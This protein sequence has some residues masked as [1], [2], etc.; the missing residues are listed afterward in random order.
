MERLFRNIKHKLSLLAFL[1]CFSVGYSQVSGPFKYQAVVR[2]AQGLIIV[3]EP[4][5]FRIG[6]IQ[7]NPLGQTVSLEE[8]QV[9][10]NQFGLVNIEI[11]TGLVLG[12]DFYT[13]DWGAD[14]YFI[15]IQFNQPSQGS[16][17]VDMGTS[18]LL[19]VPYA[20]YAREAGNVNFND[21]SATNELQQISLSTNTIQLS[22][23]GGSVDLSPYLDN[24]DS[25]T[26][27]LAGNQVSITGGN[28]ITLPV[29][30][31][32]DADSSA[33][34]ELQAISFSNDT[35]TLSNGGTVYLGGYNDAQA[36]L[37]NAQ[38]L[39][40]F[41]QKQSADSLLLFNL[42]QGNT[43]SLNGLSAQ[44][45]I[46][47][48]KQSSDS[49]LLDNKISNHIA[50]DF[51]LDSLN[52]LQALSISGDT[53]FLSN[54][55]YVILPQDRVEDADADS[56]NELQVINISNDSIFLSKGG[57]IV[58]PTDKVDDQDSDTT[59][60]VQTLSIANNQITISKGNSI[61]L[62]LDQV[63]D[64]DAD[65][66]N[67]LQ[68]LSIN[69]RTIS[70]SN[71][72]SVTVPSYDGDTSSSNEIQVISISHDTIYLKNGGFAVL[73]DSDTTNEIQSLSIKNDTIFLDKNGGFVD[74][75]DAVN[76]LVRNNPN[77]L[78]REANPLNPTC[79]TPSVSMNL[80]E[81][82]D[83]LGV[84]NIVITGAITDS[85][86]IFTIC[87]S[88]G[89]LY[90]LFNLETD[91]FAQI[92][93]I[94]YSVQGG[95]LC[96]D[97]VVYH[98][99]SNTINVYTLGPQN[100]L[101][102]KGSVNAPTPAFRTYGDFM[103]GENFIFHVRSSEF[104]QYTYKYYELD[105]NNL[106][107]TTIKTYAYNTWK[108]V[109]PLFNDTIVLDNMLY[110]ISTSSYFD[111]IPLDNIND[112]ISEL[113][114]I[115]QNVYYTTYDNSS[116]NTIYTFKIYDLYNQ[117]DN[118]L[119]SSQFKILG[120]FEKSIYCEAPNT[121]NGA[122][123]NFLNLEL[124]SKERFLFSKDLYPQRVAL[125]SNSSSNSTLRYLSNSYAIGGGKGICVN[126]HWGL[127]DY[128]FFYSPK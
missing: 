95:I 21:T 97:S 15:N 46:L 91:Y 86:F 22:N 45:T 124:S 52:E 8:H 23:N 12:G 74:L 56:L 99:A 117:E 126:G 16:G 59:N 49:L 106:S 42:I 50:Q 5:I 116:S 100:T 38:Q 26:L 77:S 32:N 48:N 39:Q 30:R 110:D 109:F 20:L 84:T 89:C 75:N 127:D 36:I 90:Y 19:S 94:S 121:T 63:E 51:D 122:K 71:G 60:E 27:S 41:S 61:T 81:K 96:K 37:F 98:W 115:D 64:A 101:V 9:T 33:I 76:N 72:N 85:I 10:T 24:T 14:K 73:P 62:P 43:S 47:S 25:Q 114:S 17:F 128:M 7:G 3:N 123:T 29:D 112:E 4:V 104:G 11:G 55:N 1:L 93:N 79:F 88:G 102:L 69:N 13:I 113:V 53:I 107:L 80:T 83:T 65:S 70:I 6:I 67:E 2:D 58:L 57:F 54:S 68:V 35:L 44:F 105:F 40:L 119:G 78:L 31:V 92:P 118:K 108:P 28:T 111:T 103:A 82:I 34:N 120:V 125:E 66:T 87:T 18:E